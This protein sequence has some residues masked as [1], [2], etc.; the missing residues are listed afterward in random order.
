MV[1]RYG[2][3]DEQIKIFLLFRRKIKEILKEIDTKGE[4]VLAII[5]KI[6]A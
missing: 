4:Y 6:K 2:K 3:Q 1:F 5:Q